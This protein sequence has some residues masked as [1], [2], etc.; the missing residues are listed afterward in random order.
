MSTTILAYV[1]AFLGLVMIEDRV[2]ILFAT[3]TNSAETLRDAHCYHVWWLWLGWYCA[4]FARLGRDCRTYP[5]YALAL[6]AAHNKARLLFFG[7]QSSHLT[8][9]NERAQR[10]P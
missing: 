5:K 1:I 2:S 8:A 6:D 4:R 10:P 9:E 3:E 7:E